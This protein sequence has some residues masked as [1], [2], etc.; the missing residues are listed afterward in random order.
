MRVIIRLRLPLFAG[1]RAQAIVAPQALE[2]PTSTFSATLK[3]C[4]EDWLV[5]EPAG[6]QRLVFP[7]YANPVSSPRVAA[8]PTVSRQ[9]SPTMIPRPEKSAP[10]QVPNVLTQAWSWLQTRYTTTSNKRMRVAETV[11]LGEKRFVALVS[12]EGREFLIGGGS[13]GVSL[14]AQLDASR[15]PV[16]AVQPGLRV[17]G[18]SE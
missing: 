15:E 2:T 16:N 10:Q 13:S 18:G 14:L 7:S 17:V 4:M 6:G 8:T 12:I 1:K 5:E 11:Q 9:T 3:D